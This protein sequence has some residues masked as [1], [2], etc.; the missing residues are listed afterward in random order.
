MHRPAKAGKAYYAVVTVV[1]GVA[2][3]RDF[4]PANS[5]PTGVNETPGPGEPI[6]Q[7]PARDD[8]KVFFDYPGGRLHYVQW[9]APPQSH[10]PNQYHNWSVFVPR[11]YE[12]ARP[13]RLSVFF[14]DYRERWLKP[15]WPH[16]PDT[17]LISPHDAPYAGFGYGYHEALGTLRSFRRGKVQP[18]L[19]RRVDAMLDWAL[20]T[21]HADAGRVSCAGGGYWGG[22]AALQYGIRRP[23]RIA[24]VCAD[25]SPD[26][27]P[28]QTPYEYGHYRPSDLRKTRRGDMDAVWGKAEWNILA[29]SGECVWDE[30]NLPAYVLA[31]G[32]KRTM[33]YLSLGAGSMH[34]TWKQETDLMKAY[35][36]TH[37]A[38]MAEFFWGGSSHRPL[39]VGAETGDWPFEP[40]SDRPMLACRP[41]V[42]TPKPEFFQKHFETGERGYS[43][44][45]R[46]NT[47]P[48][49][50][51]E[52][53]V[54]E[55][56]RLEM[57]IFSA[58][59]VVYAGRVT[60]DVVI[61]NT[62]GLRPRPGEKL[63]W[64]VASTEGRKQPQRGETTVDD[65]GLIR[66]AGVEFGEPARLIVRRAGAKEDKP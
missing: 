8:V 37:N 30:M 45:G 39:P 48:R 61:R 19:A 62:R 41:K 2:N 52:T 27:D 6:L 18:F 7:G 54:D 65:S 1:D 17:V 3:T 20:R 32:R 4:S 9:V 58:R 31:R 55:A 35:L 28:R 10:L 50:D 23:G 59:R 15:A 56:D 60:C 51:P 53:I 13:R 26:A 36:K 63:S 49:W 25:N 22:T 42:Y 44:G 43:S 46:L 33:P 64:T 14:H 11:D 5:T 12:K 16:R 47:R 66:L 24:Y 57:T 34:L 21:Y 40:R 38:F 29:D